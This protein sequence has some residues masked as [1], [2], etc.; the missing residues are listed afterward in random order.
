MTKELHH[1]LFQNHSLS[2]YRIEKPLYLSVVWNVPSDDRTMNSIRENL[3]GIIEVQKRERVPVILSDHRNY[4]YSTFN[5]E[6]MQLFQWFYPEMA[7]LGTRRIALIQS[8]NLHSMDF[9]ERMSDIVK[10]TT[11]TFRF[12]EDID[13][14]IEW[15]T[16]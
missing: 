8:M 7:R 9:L 3:E 6:A 13:K 14:G 16:K 1:K 15:L 5:P 2:I 12:F 11:L 10:E 4:H